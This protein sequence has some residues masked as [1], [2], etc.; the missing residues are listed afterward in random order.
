MSFTSF[1]SFFP[2]IATVIMR[3]IV[4]GVAGNKLPKHTKL[5]AL[6]RR[7]PVSRFLTAARATQ[8]GGPQLRLRGER[9]ELWIA[10]TERPALRDAPVAQGQSS[11]GQQLAP[12]AGVLG[13]VPHLWLL[14]AVPPDPKGPG[15]LGTVLG[16]L[17]LPHPQ[18]QPGD[19]LTLGDS[20]GGAGD[21]EPDQLRGCGGGGEVVKEHGGLWV[22][23]TPGLR[24]SATHS[25]DKK[26]QALA[27]SA[28]DP[29]AGGGAC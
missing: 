26:A 27:I 9:R 2:S 13:G 25:R 4:I 11:T 22:Q 29:A 20:P 24:E 16:G 6:G 8:P 12:L 10:L 21:Q 3:I 23:F 19:G 14:A 5:T 17:E 1:V 28:P 7:T 15:L 18:D